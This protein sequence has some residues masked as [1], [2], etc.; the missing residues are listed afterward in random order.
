MKKKIVPCCEKFLAPLKIYRPT[1]R[2]VIYVRE[3]GTFRCCA[4]HTHTHSH[5]YSKLYLTV[6]CIGKDLT[7]VNL[8]RRC[9][10]WTAVSNAM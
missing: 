7:N 4:I 8:R 1:P 6:V 2:G 9:M 10:C 5:S 3:N